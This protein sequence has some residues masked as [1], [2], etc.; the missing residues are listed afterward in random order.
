MSLPQKC[1]S[2]CNWVYLAVLVSWLWL[3]HGFGD[4]NS[5]EQ[6]GIPKIFGWLLQMPLWKRA[7]PGWLSEAQNLDMAAL[8][9]PFWEPIEQR[10]LGPGYTREVGVQVGVQ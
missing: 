10:P 3:S 4:M 2:S 6:K 9:L 5:S 8:M 7:V 1:N